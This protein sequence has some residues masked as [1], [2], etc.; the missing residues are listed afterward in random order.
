MNC[1]FI[2]LFTVPRMQHVNVC[3]FLQCNRYPLHYAYAL[4]DGEQA[5]PFIRLIIFANDLYPYQAQH[6]GLAT[7]RF[8][9]LLFLKEFFEKSYFQK[10]QHMANFLK[11]FPAC[12]E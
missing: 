9:Q 8:T 4:P 11:I 3:V 6:N 5:K 12:L 2:R 10:N 7:N 1:P